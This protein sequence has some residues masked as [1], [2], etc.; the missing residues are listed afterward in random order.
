MIRLLDTNTCIY[1]LNLGSERII[2]RFKQLS[3]SQIR[4]PSITVA[5][6]YYG[7][8]KSK[9]KSR[10]RERVKRFV[11]TFEIVPFDEK[12]CITYAKVRCKLERSGIPIGPMD[13]LIASIGLAHNF[14]VVTNNDKEF[15]RVKGL[16]VENWL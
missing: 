15:K 14:V 7:A 1:F 11:S 5:E 13:L 16:K 9:S 4:L 6:L 3:P 8:E 10:N 2:R 12:A